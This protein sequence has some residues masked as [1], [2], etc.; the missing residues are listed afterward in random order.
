MTTRRA[1]AYLLLLMLGLAGCAQP[2][3]YPLPAP[4]LTGED[5]AGDRRSLADLRGSVVIVPVWASWCG[6]CRDE[7]PVLQD[8]LGRWEDEGV[9]VLG[10]NMRDHPPSA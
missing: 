5:L 3:A 2:P 6:P 7:V 10:I 8:A 4:P 1:T 9:A